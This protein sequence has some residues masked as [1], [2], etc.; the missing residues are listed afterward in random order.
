MLFSMTSMYS[1]LTEL[2]FGQPYNLVVNT[3]LIVPR[4]LLCM[5]Y[6]QPNSLRSGK[7]RDSM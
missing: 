3:G 5:F 1:Q 2:S 7:E 6:L 4:D